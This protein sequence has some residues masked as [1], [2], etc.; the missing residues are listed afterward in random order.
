MDLISFDF[1]FCNL[2]IRFG[3]HRIEKN[4]SL[5]IFQNNTTLGFSNTIAFSKLFNYDDITEKSEIIRYIEWI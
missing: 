2:A 3:I 5:R 4:I 1:S